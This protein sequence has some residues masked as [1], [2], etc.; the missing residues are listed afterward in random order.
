MPSELMT[1]LTAQGGKSV[2]LWPTAQDITK[3]NNESAAQNIMA[4]IL[5][6][7]VLLYLDNV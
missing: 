7:A 1:R 5:S 6:P 4:A 2:K 3:K